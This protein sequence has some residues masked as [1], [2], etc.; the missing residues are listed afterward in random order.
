[1]KPKLDTKPE[2]F[3]YDAGNN[4]YYE[5]ASKEEA[6]RMAEEILHDLR[7]IAVEDTWSPETEGIRVG[8]ITHR[9]VVIREWEEDGNKYCDF[10]IKEVQGVK[11]NLKNFG[12]SDMQK[13]ELLAKLNELQAFL[14]KGT[15][16]ASNKIDPHNPSKDY[17][18]GAY[19]AYE[20]AVYVMYDIFGIEP[21]EHWGKTNSSRLEDGNIQERKL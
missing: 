12:L 17:Y 18:E 20:I 19:R 4:E 9:A 2:Y 21:P 11:M 8:V 6:L 15:D 1:M 3:V 16:E 10:S 14:V 7:A 13:E 5:F